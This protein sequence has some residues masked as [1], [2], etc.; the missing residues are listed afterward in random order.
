M[1]AVVQRVRSAS[2]KVDHSVVGSIGSGLLVF[3]AISKE[4]R[5]ADAEF[6][7]EKIVNLR[8]FEDSAGKMNRSL[9]DCG[10]GLLVVSQFTLYGDTSR[11][12]RPSFDA[13]APAAEALKLYNYFVE[14]ARKSGLA[15]ATGIFQAH[16]VAHIE[17]IGPVTFICES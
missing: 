10:G 9:K 11:G 2:V 5:A 4:D 15:I 1:R 16:M 13:A 12:R 3:L 7:L 14:I 6:L 8:V 17:N